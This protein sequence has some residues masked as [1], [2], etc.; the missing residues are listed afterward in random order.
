MTPEAIAQGQFDAYNRQDIDAFMSFYA[1]D[2]V[3]ADLNGR[4]LQTGAQQVRERYATMFAKFPANRAE[5]VNRIVVGN[6]VVDHEDVQ[7][8]PEQRFQAIA[9]YTIAD[10]RIARV[11]FAG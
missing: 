9:I 2:V 3:V 10:G 11:D 5:L 7:R 4:L 1:E 6:T 8:S